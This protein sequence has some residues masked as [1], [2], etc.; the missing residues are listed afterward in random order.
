MSV[1]FLLTA[2]LVALLLGGCR[3]DPHMQLYIDNV[4][5]E[6]RLLEDTLYDLQYDYECK[7]REVDKLRGEL[8]QLKSSGTTGGTSRPA[9]GGSRKSDTPSAPGDSMFPDIPDL[10]P[11]TVEPGTPDQAKPP[12]KDSPRGLDNMDDL[13]PPTLDLG[14][15]K[16]DVSAAPKPADQQVTQ[17]YLDTARTRGEQTDDVPGDDGIAVVFQP[18]NAD[19]NY[20][21]APARVTVALLDSDKRTRVARWEF[22]SA[23]TEAA[24]RKAREGQGIELHMRWKD[25]PPRQNRLLLFVRYWLPNGQAL[26]QECDITIT[27]P[28]KLASRWTPRAERRPEPPERRID[29]AESAG[30]ERTE[31]DPPASDASADR[32]SGPTSS[33]PSGAGSAPKQAQRPQWRPYR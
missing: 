5:A 11:P 18:R 3:N 22:T 33:S 16:S 14:E 29:V 31:S 6:K 26:E 20:V 27:P 8:T 19:N 23:E 10:K 4:N 30:E 1:R 15:K 28:G 7:I 21:P 13:E 2:G 12:A 32:A 24:L 25:A 17:L 9:A